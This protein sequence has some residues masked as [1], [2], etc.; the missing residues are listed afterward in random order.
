MVGVSVAR[1]WGP[2]GLAEA[3]LGPEVL[4]PERAGIRVEDMLAAKRTPDS[5]S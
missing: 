5:G 1:S 3:G 2:L 4:S